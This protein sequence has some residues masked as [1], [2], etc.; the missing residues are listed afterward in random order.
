MELCRS[1]LPGIE[2][3]IPIVCNKQ[4][5]IQVLSQETRI[6][7]G[8]IPQEQDIVVDN[9]L[10]SIFQKFFRMLIYAIATYSKDYLH[11][12]SFTLLERL[13]RVSERVDN[14]E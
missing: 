3:V 4:H 14:D 7:N 13:F 11:E 9:V 8:H 10:F 6:E 5:I 1:S 12:N 2:A